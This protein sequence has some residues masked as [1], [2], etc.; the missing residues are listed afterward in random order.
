MAGK[1]QQLL[2]YPKMSSC[3]KISSQNAKFAASF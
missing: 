1:Q 2:E 3:Q